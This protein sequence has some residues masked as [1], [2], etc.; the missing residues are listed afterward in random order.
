MA[1]SLAPGKELHF[2]GVQESYETDAYTEQGEALYT[3][4]GVQGKVLTHNNR[5]EAIYIGD[6]SEKRIAAEKANQVQDLFNWRP[7]N[8][9]QPGTDGPNLWRQVCIQRNAYKWDGRAAMFGH[10]KVNFRAIPRG[11]QIDLSTK[12]ER[13]Q[14]QEVQ[15]FDQQA[16]ATFQDFQNF[17]TNVQQAAN[18]PYQQNPQQGV[19]MFNTGQQTPQQFVQQPA[20]Q[21]SG[22]MFN[23]GQPGQAQQPAPVWQTQQ[24]QLHPPANP[25]N[26]TS[27]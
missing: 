18:Q 12:A 20:P 4:A 11:A 10:A 23:A 24:A 2:K 26:I 15:V 5:V 3:K 9:D 14:Q 19:T 22:V 1:K 17:Q 27:M 16:G 25:A 7:I 6:D 13:Q 8:W 21:Q